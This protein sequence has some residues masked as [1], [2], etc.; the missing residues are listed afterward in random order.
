MENIYLCPSMMCADFG[1]LAS[2]VE[3]LSEAGADIF[4]LDLMDGSFVPNF[5]MGFEDIKSIKKA[6][7]KPVDV[8]MMIYEPSKHVGALCDMGI[9]IIYIHPEADSQPS[10][11]LAS[12]KALGASPGIAVNPGTSFEA[13]RELLHIASHVLVMTVNPGYAG[14]QY[15]EFVDDK[16]YI[17]AE[18]KRFYDYEIFVDGA[19]SEVKLKDLRSKG[20]DGFVLGTSA[21]FGKGES[22]KDI[23]RNLRDR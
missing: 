21:L 7:T 20:V 14:Q 15:L 1:N 22:Y 6:S 3:L 9:D 16:L 4:H 11:T 2:E 5:A 17:F 19:I 8:H 13:V 18:Y 10:R 12:I 23:M